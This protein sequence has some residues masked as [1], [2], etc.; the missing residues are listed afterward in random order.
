MEGLNKNEVNTPSP[1]SSAVNKE[2]ELNFFI[3]ENNDVKKKLKEKETINNKKN[4]VFFLSDFPWED[5][6]E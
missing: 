6:E 3:S 4:D 2:K 5:C 1:I